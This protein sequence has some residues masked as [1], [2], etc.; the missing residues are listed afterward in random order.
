[1]QFV[2]DKINDI[3]EAI[4]VWIVESIK[5]PFESLNSLKE[6]VFG[7]AG[8]GELVWGTFHPSDLTD[9]L[10]P[11]Y[12]SIA[13]IAG[14]VLIAFI[15]VH[16]MRI[17][18]ASINPG[19]R[20]EMIH[21]FFDLGI[22]SIVLLNLQT[23]YDLLFQIN[24][25]VVSIFSG[26]YES[27]LDTL[28]DQQFDDGLEGILGFL[29]V[30][31]VLLGL[32]IWA[33]FYYFMRKV[34][35]IILMAMGPLMLVFYLN[36]KFKPITGSWM[37]ELIGSI[38]V[39]A[40]HAF[41]FWVVATLSATSDGLIETVILYAI[42]IPISESLRGLIGMGGG[43][44]GTLSKAGA[45]MGMG[46]LAGVYG[47]AKGAMGGQ[48]VMDA[49]K[50]AAKGAK[51]QIGGAKGENGDPKDIKNTLGSN[52]GSDI[53]TTY[54]ADKML[55]AG[56]IFSRAGKATM[57]AAGAIAG[58]GLGPVASMTGASIGTVGGD[59]VGGA[60]GRG[61]AALVQGIGDR[62]S[63]GKEAIKNKQG[64]QNTG[65]ED[66]L[67]NSIANRETTSW[68]DSHKAAVMSDLQERFPNASPKELESHFNDIKTAKKEE[69][70]QQA[71]SNIASLKSSGGNMASGNAMVNASSAAMAENWGSANQQSFNEAYDKENLNGQAYTQ[72]YLAKRSNAFAS[73]KAEMKNA[74]ADI[75]N[76][77]VSRNA[78]NG[79]EPISKAGFQ[80]HMSNAVAG[81][82]G[83]GNASALIGASD[84]AINHV[85]GANLM[86]ADGKPN[87][88]FIVGGLAAQKTNQMRQSYISSQTAKGISENDA[89]RDWQQNHQGNVHSANVAT[90][91]D[92]LNSA[93]KGLQMTANSSSIMG[94]IAN[95]NTAAFVSGATGFASLKQVTSS[96]AQGASVALNTNSGGSF[97]QQVKAA[98]QGGFSE[99]VQQQ[100]GVIEAQ[101]KLQ[102][103][104]GY[105]LGTVTVMGVK[106]Y[107]IGKQAATS[108]SPFM[109]RV[110]ESISTPSEVMQMARTVTDSNGNVQVA[111]GAIRQV[112]TQD[113][114]YIEVQTKSGTTQMVSR[115]GAGHS[116][117]KQGEV[118]YQDLQVS[119]DSLM[120]M[121]SKSGQSSAYRLD[122][123]GARIPSRVQVTQNPV[124]LLSDSV[125][126][127]MK[128]API[129]KAQLPIFN[130]QVESG[131]FSVEDLGSKGFENVQVVMEKNRQFVT[132]NKE[133]I[134][135]RVSPVFAGD[136]RM[137]SNE[138]IQIPVTVSGSQLKPQ[139]IPNSLNAVA[140]SEGKSY[141]S[142]QRFDDL[143]VGLD[144]IMPSKYQEHASRS[145]ARREYLDSVRRKQGILG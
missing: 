143:I 67:A 145:V 58:M 16:A 55:K 28:N 122:S 44:Q 94:K 144:E 116:G 51:G 7:K 128:A 96:A 35:L 15:A 98:V 79:T 84:S 48:N 141:Y 47:A 131:Q 129:Q 137:G 64:L 25:G 120:P 39:Q 130:H 49:V 41:V 119:N 77:Y 124:S 37:K 139:S 62:I 88:G 19:R 117:L 26:S 75:G 138:T 1:M 17:A 91:S 105:A 11:V 9:A 97:T 66:G 100:G 82:E 132:A 87:T 72:D 13:T 56:D 23:F 118:V 73:K 24:G 112:I 71:K 20:N 135:Y 115:K 95:S 63:K 93:N 99:V 70:K 61:G 69:F 59:I 52:P 43:M 104:S 12:Y 125:Q 140:T 68:A 106:G 57:G 134:T 114:S 92:S 42:F 136:T 113:S 126:G 34:T 21:F 127:S 109:S 80:K 102:N 32:M 27:N 121:A 29:L 60:L 33:N 50:G 54:K 133:G 38:F 22:V 81:M 36:P 5:K 18:K 103:I 108:I 89:S 14:F 86:R 107:Q 2:A 76:Q 10:V 53:G 30:Q 74:F 101:Q 123:G 6:L 110:Q 31:L 90:F 40:I 46:A 83:V 78:V 4:F 111:P 85:T 65:F 142:T 8:N 3:L 45:M